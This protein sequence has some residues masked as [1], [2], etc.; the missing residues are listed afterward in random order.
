MCIQYISIYVLI[1][2][3]K[4]IVYTHVHVYI[5]YYYV[6]KN[7]VIKSYSNYIN[8]ERMWCNV[9]PFVFCITSSKWYL[10]Q[11][12]QTVLINL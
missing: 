6:F 7:I 8:T 9:M 10:H 4:S 1:P 2:V 3:S 5:Q 11:S 12:R